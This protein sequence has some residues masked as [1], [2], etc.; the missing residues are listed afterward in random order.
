MTVETTTGLEQRVLKAIRAHF[1]RTG[2]SPSY[3]ELSAAVGIL[4][5]H[6]GKPLRSLQDKGFL[7]FTRGAPRSI[8][9]ADRMAN[10]A[11]SEIELAAAARGAAVA[12]AA[13]SASA[14]PA[15]S[16]TDDGIGNVPGIPHRNSESGG[17]DE[18]EQEGEAAS[19]R[20]RYP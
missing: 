19:R 2:G 1:R 3:G 14:W 11:D 18:G 15:A 13:P 20:H 4:A 5:Q 7:R 10:F 16:V 6:V 12:W 8:V 9:L 17:S